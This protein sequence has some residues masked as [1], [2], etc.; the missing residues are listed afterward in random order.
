MPGLKTFDVPILLWGAIMLLASVVVSAQETAEE[1]A[2]PVA[3]AVAEA[4]ARNPNPTRRTIT[5]R[6]GQPAD[7]QAADE[8]V[9][10]LAANDATEWNPYDGWAD[11][12]DAGYAR[13]LTRDEIT[14]GLVSVAMDGAVTGSVAGDLLGREDRGA[15]VGAGVALAFEIVR[16]DFLLAPEDPLLERAVKDFER[17]LRYWEKKYAACLRP[18]GYRVT[19][20]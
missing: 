14:E 17:K 4:P 18:K 19:T 5:P 12:V 20:D 10:F 1:S 8:R 11:L 3:E 7:Q 16:T 15:E 9:C 13:A 2:S 6:H